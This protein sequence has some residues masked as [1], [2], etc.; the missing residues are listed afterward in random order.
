[1]LNHERRRAFTLIELLVVIAIIALLA[2]LLLP[3]LDRARQRAR[4][5]AC[6]S[7]IRQ[8]GMGSRMYADEND[9]LL[10]RS[11]H[12]GASWVLTLQS[13]VN[14]T[15]LWRCPMDSNRTRH[16]SYALNDFLLPP[17]AWL[18]GTDYSKTTQVPSPTDTF[19]L[20]ECDDNYKFNDHF[21]FTEANDGNYTPASFAGQVAV[22]RH[23]AAAGYLFVDG[24]A[25]LLRWNLVQN[26]LITPGSRFVNPAGHP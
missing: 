22:R 19:W 9:D 6:L 4:A 3:A 18:G 12:Q 15:N 23:Q 10:P 14:G 20:G 13:Y 16:F 25:Q 17:P 24:H 1:M 8:I 5:T 2:A 7:G 26:Q 11:A 21:H